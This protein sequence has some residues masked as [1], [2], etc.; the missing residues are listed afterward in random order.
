M[1]LPIEKVPA[2]VGNPRYLVLYGKP[3]TGKTTIVAAIPNNLIIDLEGGSEFMD[4]LAIQARTIQDLSAIAKAIRDKFTETGKFPYEY[5]TIDSATALEDIAKQYA[6]TLYQA[7]PMAKDKITGKIYND[8]IL[9]LPQGGGYYYL[10]EAFEKIVSMFRVLCKNLILICHCKEA[11]IN[12]DGREMSEM[13]VDLS[14]KL[15]RIVAANSDAIGLVYRVGKKTFINFNGGSDSIVEARAP[16][17]RGQE[18][19]ISEADDENNVTVNWE[20]LYLP[21]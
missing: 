3:K 16:H 10:R 19:L 13:T 2:K 20:K 17:L 18:I 14:G 8:D 12:K 21:E 6:L 9:K 11:L 7:T 15:A 5:I 1:L 4:S